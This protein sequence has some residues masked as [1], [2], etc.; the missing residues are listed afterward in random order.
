M[1]GLPCSWKRCAA[2]RRCCIHPLFTA[3][4]C[5]HLLL[6]Y[7]SQDFGANRA[8]LLSASHRPF[9]LHILDQIV[10]ELAE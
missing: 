3:V 1:G 6:F 2:L 8:Y 7:D 9:G 10:A 5:E 4:R